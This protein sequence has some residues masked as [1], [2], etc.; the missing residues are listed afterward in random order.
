MLEKGFLSNPLAMERLSS[1]SK[2]SSQETESASFPKYVDLTKPDDARS[3]LPSVNLFPT[4][5]QSGNHV[6]GTHVSSNAMPNFASA[7][8][9]SQLVRYY[10]IY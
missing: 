8:D 10:L 5:A 2:Q 6:S 3:A 4:M 7:P 1:D 9:F